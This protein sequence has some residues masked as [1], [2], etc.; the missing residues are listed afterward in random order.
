MTKLYSNLW[1]LEEKME[2]ISG[3][4]I[5]GNSLKL[6]DMHFNLKDHFL[7]KNIFTVS[8]NGL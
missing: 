2:V 4:Y 8:V 3:E 5:P 7:L 1:Y 6:G